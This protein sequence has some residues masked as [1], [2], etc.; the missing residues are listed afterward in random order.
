EAAHRD[1]HSSPTRRSS[2]L[3]ALEDEVQHGHVVAER[4]AEVEGEHVLHVH[5]EA[6]P[7]RLVETESLAELR[8]VLGR[9][10]ARLAG[11]D[12]CGVRSEEHTSELQ[13]LAYLVCR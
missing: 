4:E 11:E 8:H 2:D 9:G 12:L 6:E 7:E 3:Q 10:R 13:S 5:E 1:L